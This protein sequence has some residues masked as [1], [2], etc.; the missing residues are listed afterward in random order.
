MIVETHRRRET[1]RTTKVTQ[2][3]VHFVEIIRENSK[4]QVCFAAQLRNAFTVAA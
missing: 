4:S 3:V 2:H 1:P